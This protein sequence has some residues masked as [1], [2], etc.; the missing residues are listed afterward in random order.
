MP[1]TPPRL[2]FTTRLTVEVAPPVDLG[3]LPS[4]HRRVVPI[5]GGRAAGPSVNGVIR[6]A[7]ADMQTLRAPDLMDLDAEY[8]I[9]T[10]DG[11]VVAVRNRGVRV[12]S[13]EDTAALLRGDPVPAERVHF[14]TVPV[15]LSDHP[16]WTWLART[17]FV[18]TALRHPDVVEVDVFAVI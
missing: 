10:D 15:L 16:D 9:D 18:A 1:P 4:G 7:G 3:D 13:P 8:L 5:V 2:R 6:P 14:R 12:A 17:V 11:A